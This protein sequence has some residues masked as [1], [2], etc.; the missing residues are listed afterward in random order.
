MKILS[1]DIGIKNLAYCLL[2][3][4]NIDEWDIID[5]SGKDIN[6]ISDILIQKLNDNFSH[7]DYDV[8]LIENQPVMKN[9]IM[10][11]I[12][13]IIYSYFKYLKI[14]E[15]KNIDK[16]LLVSAN[17]KNKFTSK[18]DLNIGKCSSK[19][20]Q[21][22]KKAIECTKILLKDQEELFNFFMSHKKKDDLADSYLQGLDYINKI[23]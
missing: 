13:I 20:L 18:Y 11:S 14:I 15:N 16:I 19:Y 8:V 2:D 5:I 6:N 21:N 3:N 1:F 7:S 4:E 9:P 22:K 17:N 10:K 23:K 12:Q